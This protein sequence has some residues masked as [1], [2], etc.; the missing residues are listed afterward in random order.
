M[1]IVSLFA[2][3]VEVVFRKVVMD[4]RIGG[5]MQD[6]GVEVTADEMLDWERVENLG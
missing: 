2:Y 6:V 5:L 4:R 1:K 3:C